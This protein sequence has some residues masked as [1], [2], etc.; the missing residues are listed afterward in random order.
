MVQALTPTL[1][2]SEAGELQVQGQTGPH[3]RLKA[4]LGYSSDSSQNEKAKRGLGFSSVVKLLP[5]INEDLDQS[6]YHK[7]REEKN[8]FEKGL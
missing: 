7:E 6:Q 1:W 5:N 3:S 4:S 2:K 8:L